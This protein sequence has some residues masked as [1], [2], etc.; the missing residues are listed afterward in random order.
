[1]GEPLDTGSLSSA[2]GHVQYKQNNAV[3]CFKA[4]FPSLTPHSGLYIIK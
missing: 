3:S 2:S 1:M 4:L